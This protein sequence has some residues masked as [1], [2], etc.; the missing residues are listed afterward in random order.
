MNKKGTV[1][2]I[3][4]FCTNDGPGIRTTVFLKGCPL[5][6]L[7]CHNPEGQNPDKQILFYRDKCTHCGKCA[8]LTVDD[9]DFFC[10]NDAKKI[11]GKDLLAEEIMTEVLKDRVYYKN[12]GGGLTLSGGE[13]LGHFV[14][15]LELLR[16]AKAEGLHTCVETSGCTPT[17]EVLEIAKFTDLFLF[18]WKITNSEEHKKYTG[19]GN[20]LIKKN[21]LELDKSGAKIILRC[22]IIPGVN[23]K[24]EH[25]E[26]ISALANSLKGVLEVQI[27]P[28][29]SLGVH[30]YAALSKESSPH[31]FPVPEESS[32]QKWLEEISSRTSVP[33]KLA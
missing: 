17:E 13:P 10:V 29:H 3:Q 20:E 15:A 28:Y 9:A 8:D 26:G 16:L 21:L 30:K 24:A 22:P 4:R 1:F 5:N 23:D 19:T 6:C 11:C 18:D 14:F 27:E 32:A 7:W 2:N 33:V 31:D 12:S 25:F